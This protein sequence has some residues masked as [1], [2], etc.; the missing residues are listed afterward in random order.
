MQHLRWGMWGDQFICYALFSPCFL[1]QSVRSIVGINYIMGF[2]WPASYLRRS[3][4]TDQIDAVPIPLPVGKVVPQVSTVHRHGL[5]GTFQHPDVVPD[6]LGIAK[7][8]PSVHLALGDEIVQGPPDRRDEEGLA[9]VGI[10]E[11][12][13]T[14]RLVHDVLEGGAPIVSSEFGEVT[15]V[16]GDLVGEL[17]R[18]SVSQIFL[19]GNGRGA[20]RLGGH[21]RF[22][23][24]Y[25]FPPDLC[26]GGGGIFL[27]RRRRVGEEEGR[28]SGGGG[29]RAGVLEE[30]SSAARSAIGGVADG[31]GG[32]VS[33]EEENGGREQNTSGGGP[34]G[35]LVAII[36][37]NVER[38]SCRYFSWCP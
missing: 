4:D 18:D 33:G 23:P 36:F 38:R 37:G 27:L 30:G 6:D 13:R 22:V 5:A 19:D 15:V 3:S 17:V 28:Q 7:A 16:I 9:G 12:H 31:E 8:R 25:D 2:S 20:V 35:G 29:G 1:K 10:V 14:L 32:R 24:Q 34:H 21:D 26:R 11:R